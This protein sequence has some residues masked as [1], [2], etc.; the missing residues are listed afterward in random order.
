MEPLGSTVSR[1]ELVYRMI[2]DNI[3]DCRLEPGTHLVQEELAATLGVSRQPIQQAMLL[4]KNDGL[5]VEQGARGLY[6]APLDPEAIGHH[7]QIRLAFDQLAAELVAARAA[8]S[9]DFAQ[10]LRRR[11]DIILE[12]GERARSVGAAEAVSH[13]VRFHTFLY[14]QSGNPL[15]APAADMHWNFLRRVMVAVL[16]HAERGP[17][18]WSQ[19]REI[20]DLLVAGK[21]RKACELVTQH[22]LGAKEA[23]LASLA[24]RA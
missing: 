23:L 11:G 13:D 5:V 21:R 12:E 4:L 18:V 24:D 20:L 9:L 1:A 19:H 17:V 2:R 7:Y 6:V 10:E 16:L 15:I 3:R 14:E 22:I 8:G